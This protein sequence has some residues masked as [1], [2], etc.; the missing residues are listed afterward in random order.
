MVAPVHQRARVVRHERPAGPRPQL[1]PGRAGARLRAVPGKG[2]RP[3]AG[4]TGA[5]VPGQDR[6]SAADHRPVA[7][8]AGPA[9][10]PGAVPGQAARGRDAARDRGGIRRVRHPAVPAVGRRP[11]HAL[12]LSGLGGA[13][14]APGRGLLRAG[15][16]VR[17]RPVRHAGLAR[18]GPGRA[19]RPA[20]P[21]P[22]RRDRSGPGRADA[23]P[24]A[25]PPGQP[26]RAG[27]RACGLP[28]RVRVT[29]AEPG[30][31]PRAGQR[32][33][34]G[35]PRPGAAHVP[36]AAGRGPGSG[37]SRRADP[38]LRAAGRRRA[39][40]WGSR[41][42]PAH[43]QTGPRPGAWPQAGPTS[44]ARSAARPYRSRRAPATAT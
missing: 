21:H 30:P 34:G 40:A 36:P 31:A 19:A 4:V 14:Q 3:G 8:G 26:G 32:A 41:V 43:L 2:H 18:Q 35:R 39:G 25:A 10:Q 11:G 17:P 27:P 29:R 15:R 42:S 5:P 37:P 20:A 44:P 7:A 23:G 1:R 38:R 13:V 24:G 28:G 33:G 12:Q 16:G 9:G 22:G 6:G